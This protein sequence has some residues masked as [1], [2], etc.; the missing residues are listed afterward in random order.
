MWQTLISLSKSDD[1]EDQK[2]LRAVYGIAFFGVP[3]DG[4]DIKS[5]ISMAGDGPNRFLL[6]SIGNQGSQIL[7][8]YNRDFPKTLGGRGE[9]KIICF[10]ETLLSPTA[11]MV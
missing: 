5:L 8:I 4:M 2:L 9:S 7:G 10:Y 6:E 11:T 3:H 1:E